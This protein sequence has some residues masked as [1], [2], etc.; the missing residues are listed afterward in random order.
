MKVKKQSQQVQVR[1]F[2]G[3]VIKRSSENEHL[4]ESDLW[5]REVSVMF[6]VK[7]GMEKTESVSCS[8]VSGSL[9]C[10]GL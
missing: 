8:V 9:R 5:F 7:T 6:C 1:V 2:R 10:H 4:L 3:V